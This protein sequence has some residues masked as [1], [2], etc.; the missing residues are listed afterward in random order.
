M[1]T[2]I[3][4]KTNFE[5]ILEG[6]WSDLGRFRVEIG[7]TVEPSCSKNQ[8]KSRQGQKPALLRE[9]QVPEA[10]PEGGPGAAGGGAPVLS[11]LPG[12]KSFKIP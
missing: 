7:A 10:P 12:S 6:S 5:G 8:S 1:N 2:E 4:N 11:T 9:V 3:K